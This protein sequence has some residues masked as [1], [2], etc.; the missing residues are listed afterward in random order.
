MLGVAPPILKV[1]SALEQD[2]GVA[3]KSVFVCQFRPDR[4]RYTVAELV[5]GSLNATA[6]QFRYWHLSLFF[7]GAV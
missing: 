3:T 7:A 5:E 1:R 6:F 2:D 4:W